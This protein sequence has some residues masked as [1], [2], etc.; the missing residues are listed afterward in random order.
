[1]GRKHNKRG[2]AKG[3]KRTNPGGTRNLRSEII[4]ILAKAGD[5]PQNYKQVSAALG[6]TDGPVRTL[7]R[8]ILTEE[9]AKGNVRETSH[10]KYVLKHIPKKNESALDGTTVLDTLRELQISHVCLYHK[11]HN[12]KEILYVKYFF[13]GL[14]VLINLHA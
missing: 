14:I 9:V 10:H 2:K 4:D 8:E 11:R 5:T 13:A 12:N 1:M 6:I 3:P 7:I